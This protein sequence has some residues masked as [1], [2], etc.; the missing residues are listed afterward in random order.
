MVAAWIRAEIG[1]G[2]SMAS[3]SHTCR[4]NW[5]DLA[6]GPINTSRQRAVAAQPAMLPSA[7]LAPRPV[8]I[9][10]KSKLP[11]AQNRPRMPSNRPKSPT[12]FTTNAFWAAWAAPSRSYQKPTSR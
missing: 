10:S 2:P 3:G 4:G 5:A 8:A 7:M 1:V 9:P 12:R 11:V 6:M